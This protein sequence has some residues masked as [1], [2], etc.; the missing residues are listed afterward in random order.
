MKRM[1]DTQAEAAFRRRLRAAIAAR[2]D[3]SAAALS[4]RLGRNHA[5]L[6]QYLTRG[7]PRRLPLEDKLAIAEL[8]GIAP[9]ELGIPG[10]APASAQADPHRLDELPVFR[11]GDADRLRSWL[12]QR[13]GSGRRERPQAP[14][15]PA[16][17]QCPRLGVFLREALPRRAFVLVHGDDALA[18]AVRP[19]DLLIVD[20]HVREPMDDAIHVIDLGP[21]GIAVRRIFRRGGD[22]VLLA[23]DNVPPAALAALPRGRVAVLGR[24]VAVVR[25]LA[26]GWPAG[27]A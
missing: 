17:A 24:V 23:A 9:A 26:G 18:P 4:R 25:A 22:L 15:D 16:P 5:Y 7:S 12:A 11:P 21:A 10:P 1:E 13:D 6:H 2:H 27:G 20:A 3:V 19:G 8:L 14:P